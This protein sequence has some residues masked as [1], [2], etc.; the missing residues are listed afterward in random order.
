[1]EAK[2]LSE[3]VLFVWSY[4]RTERRAARPVHNTT[5]KQ[6]N[7]IFEVIIFVYA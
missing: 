2:K 6:S 7:H 4:A 3:F 5:F 1:M